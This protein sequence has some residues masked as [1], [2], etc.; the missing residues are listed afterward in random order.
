MNHTRAR[1]QQGSLTREKRQ[2]G[3]DVWVYRWRENG[4]SGQRINRKRIVGTVADLRSK[5]AAQKLVEGLRLDINAIVQTAPHSYTVAELITHYLETELAEKANKT[6]LTRKVYRYHLEKIILPV[7]GKYRLQDVR[8]VAIERWLES[9]PGAPS[10]KAKTRNIFSTLFRHGM[11][12]EWVF[13]NPIELVRQGAK[14]LVEP[15]ILTEAEIRTLIEGLDEPARTMVLVAAVTG[16]RRG[17][18]FGLRWQD[19]D[20]QGLTIRIACSLVDQVEGA[21][22]TVTS[23][24]SIPLSPELARA[25][26]EW[27]RTT[28]FTG[29]SDW[30]F[31]SPASLGKQPYWPGMILRRHIAPAAQRLGI[32]KK[33]GWHTFRRTTATLLFSA[34]AS[35]KTT[36]ELMRHASPSITL[37]L[38]AQAVTEDKRA[39]HN[40]LSK[41]IAG[42][43]DMGGETTVSAYVP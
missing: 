14:R 1:Y 28:H 10:S 7:W 4:S 2:N 9:R 29:E 37:G 42:M 27:K 34:G 6:A 13:S 3:S 22:K 5:A 26:G 39:A 8:T 21:P 17:E 35:V 11:R 41:A 36:Q 24:T 40:A 31:S 15:D 20:F 23:R 16:L 33:I 38:Y 30:V 19:V 43:T 18:L 32:N 25:L 12:Y